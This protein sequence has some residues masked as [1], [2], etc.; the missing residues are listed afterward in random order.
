MYLKDIVGKDEIVIFEGTATKQ[1]YESAYT[2][3]VVDVDAVLQGYVEAT[4]FV[5][6]R[7]DETWGYLCN[8]GPYEKAGTKSVYIAERDA[9]GKYQVYQRLDLGSSVLDELKSNLAASDVEGSVVEITTT[10]RM[11]QI[12]TTIGDM[13]T[14]MVILLKEYSFW[15]NM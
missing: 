10:D 3:E 13:L 11:N 12:M 5:Y 8:Q 14:E 7:K 15:K 2:A 6:H 1:M 9:Y 4:T